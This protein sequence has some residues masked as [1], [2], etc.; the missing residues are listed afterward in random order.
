MKNLLRALWY[1]FCGI[2]PIHGQPADSC[3]VCELLEASASQR[4]TPW[5]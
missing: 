2:C 1:L 4:H 5:N 3:P